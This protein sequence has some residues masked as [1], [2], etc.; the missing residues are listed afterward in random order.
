MGNIDKLCRIAA[1]VGSITVLAVLAQPAVAADQMA[2]DQCQSIW[3]KADSAKAGSLTQDQAAPYISDFKA[4][5]A[6]GNGKLSQDEFMA[7]CAKGLVHDSA[8]AGASSGTAGSSSGA[9]Q[10]A[11]PAPAQ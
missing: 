1:T 6:S 8:G 7:A 2:Q 3:G 9:T 11:Q 10:P 4:A 5:N